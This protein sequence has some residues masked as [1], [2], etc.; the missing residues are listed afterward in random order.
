MMDEKL[1]RYMVPDLTDFKVEKQIQFNF[2]NHYIDF[3]G[4]H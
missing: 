1:P 3:V 4:S 2:S